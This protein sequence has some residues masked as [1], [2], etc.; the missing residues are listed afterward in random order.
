MNCNYFHL[1]K[2]FFKWFYEFGEPVIGQDSFFILRRGNRGVKKVS[3]ALC[4]VWGPR[5]P[6]LRGEYALRNGSIQENCVLSCR[7]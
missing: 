6:F 4:G 5:A 7:T 1:G 2:E 3:F